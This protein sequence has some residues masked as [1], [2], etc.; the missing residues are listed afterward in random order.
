MTEHIDTVVISSSDSEQHPITE[1]I[2]RKKPARKTYMQ[3]Y[4]LKHKGVYTCEH[5]ERIYTCRSSLTKH[6]GSS[7]KCYV[8][9]IK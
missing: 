7:I 4:Y 2:T 5:C 1:K 6:Q 3:D 8:E 9:R